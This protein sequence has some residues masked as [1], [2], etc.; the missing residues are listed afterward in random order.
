MDRGVTGSAKNVHVKD[1][2]VGRE[3]NQSVSAKRVR[4]RLRGQATAL[5]PLAA[6]LMPARQNETTEARLDVFNDFV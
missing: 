2:R 3:E 4:T 1:C 5:K 6:W